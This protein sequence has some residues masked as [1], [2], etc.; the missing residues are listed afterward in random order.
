MN[1]DK[2]AV[3][4]GIGSGLG[5]AIARRFGV[6]GFALGLMA[7]SIEK[8]T[9]IQRELELSKFYQRWSSKDEARFF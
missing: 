2:V 8:L 6:E 3:I 9:P 1:S 4:L 5:A 7:R